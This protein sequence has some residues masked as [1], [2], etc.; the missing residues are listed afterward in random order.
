M[1][2]SPILVPL[3]S[4]RYRWRMIQIW[5]IFRLYLRLILYRAV[6]T[7]KYG[8]VER[9]RERAFTFKEMNSPTRTLLFTMQSN[10]LY[11]S[12]GIILKVCEFQQEHL[13][14]GIV[15]VSAK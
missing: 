3:V 11:R 2:S 12:D 5:I 6:F 14:V 9:E 7:V 10:L 1:C 8:T 15:L 4:R 13:R